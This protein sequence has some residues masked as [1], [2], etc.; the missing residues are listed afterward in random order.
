MGYYVTLIAADFTIPETP[1]VLAAIHGMDVRFDA[2]KRGG[3]I[4]GDKPQEKW[5]S[6]MPKLGTLTSVQEVFETL[7]FDTEIDPETGNVGLV[8]YDNKTGQED[9]FLAVVAPFVKDGSYTVWRGEDG[10]LCRYEVTEG[11]LTVRNSFVQWTEP[12][13]FAIA[14]YGSVGSFRDGT[15]LGFSILVDPYNDDETTIMNLIDDQI[16][17]L[18]GASKV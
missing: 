7:G 18:R 3:V 17:D 15:Y 16:Q 2:L 13:P 14:H 12:E 5:F 4:G 9:L 10:M 8:G 1:E 6:W 11:R